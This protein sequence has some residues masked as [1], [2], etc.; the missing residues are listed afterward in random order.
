ML[1]APADPD[2]PEARVLVK[3]LDAAL[4][5]IC[6]DS[7]SGSFDPADVRGPSAVFLMARDGNGTALGCGALR[8]LAP[9]V[10]EL[11]RMYARPGSGAGLALL[12][13][14][15]AQALAF[16]YQEIWLSTRRVN[17]KALA[18]YA[19]NGYETV[20][21]YGRY[22]GREESACLGKHLG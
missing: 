16:G 14:L 10:A 17:L 9:G 1:C 8:P 3:E 18:F 15:E 22:V 12:R 21:H 4:A 13:A 20:A 11:K 19:R 6:G 5:A 7:G 2:S